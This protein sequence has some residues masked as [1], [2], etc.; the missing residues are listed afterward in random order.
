MTSFKSQPLP[1][2]TETCDVDMTSSIP[3]MNFTSAIDFI[4]TDD[5]IDQVTFTADTV[6]ADEQWVNTIHKLL[7]S[8]Y[9]HT[10]HFFKTTKC[11]RLHN[12]TYRRDRYMHVYLRDVFLQWFSCQT[13]QYF[14]SM[15]RYDCC[16][17]DNYCRTPHQLFNRFV[18]FTGLKTGEG[19]KYFTGGENQEKLNRK[20]LIQW[21]DICS[22]F[23]KKEDKIEA[24]S[25]NSRTKVWLNTS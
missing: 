5:A 24:F 7:F 14:V 18:N 21:K 9:F 11:A 13:L 23:S 20:T 17:L 1:R 19:T 2:S 22:G 10:L 25:R 3:E 16:Y 6:E 15:V 4:A 12:V 8:W